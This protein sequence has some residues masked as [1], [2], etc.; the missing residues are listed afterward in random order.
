MS[1]KNITVVICCAG[2]GTRLGIGTTKALININ[3]KPLIYHQLEL[4][5]D[6]EDVRIVVGFQAEEV[7][8]IVN[9]YRKDV[10]YVFNYDYEKNGPAASLSRALINTKQYVLIMDGDVLINKKDFYDFL[11]YPQECIAISDINTDEPIKVKIDSKN[12][13]EFDDDGE[14]EWTG[15]AKICS[16]KL[17]KREDYVYEMLKPLLPI[18]YCKIRTRDIDTPDDYDKALKWLNDDYNN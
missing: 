12:V 15:I 14:F 3:N 7:I 16:D 11:N 9:M 13:V 6:F 4:L 1:I 18:K 8:K 17:I 2:M 5:K 10:M